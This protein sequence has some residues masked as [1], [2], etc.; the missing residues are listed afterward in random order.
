MSSIA[1]TFQYLLGRIN[2]ELF[3]EHRRRKHRGRIIK[4]MRIADDMA[5]LAEDESILK[6]MLIDL[7]DTCED[8]GLKINVN[9]TKVMVIGRKPKKIDMRNKDQ[10]VEQVYSF[11]YLGVISEAT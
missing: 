3:P 4:C 5:L 6:N 9:K 2:E 11:K 1:Y 10:S 7:N 8:Y